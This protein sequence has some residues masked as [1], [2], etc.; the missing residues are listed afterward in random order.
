[1]S[2]ESVL[3][4]L[5]RRSWV[6]TAVAVVVLWRVATLAWPS[7]LVTIPDP[8]RLPIAL[9]GVLFLICGV[10]TWW[11]RPGRWSAIFLVSALGSGVHWGGTIGSAYTGL[12]L[13]LFFIYLAFTTLGE[14]GLLHLAL[15]FPREKTLG[16][17]TR[18]ALYAVTA[19]AAL[20]APLAGLLPKTILE[21]MVG[22]ILMFANLVG[23]SAGLLFLVSLFRVD[24]ATRRATRLPL[25]V[26]SMLV[27]T[28]VATLGAEGILLQ[29][30]DAWNLVHGLFPISLA[31]A[32][33]SLPHRVAGEGFK[34]R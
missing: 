26:T 29:Q 31:I 12:E 11:I 13:S 18:I 16:P 19:L 8:I 33:V 2:G 30:S 14:A 24:S 10:W 21:P 20:V 27:A 15:I 4:T 9:L 28:I 25:I 34:S 6:V 3:P 1:M 5:F 7:S 23:L 17:S 32:L 22:L